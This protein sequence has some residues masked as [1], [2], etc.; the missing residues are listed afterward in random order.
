LTNGTTYYYVVAATNT[1]GASANSA[2]AVGHP[3]VPVA[4]ITASGGAGQVSL[5]WNSL[6]GASSYTVERS[7]TAGGPYTNLVSGLTATSYTDTSVQAGHDYYYIVMAQLSNGGQSGISAEV[8]ALTAP[9][10]PSLVLSQF[11][12][13]VITINPATAD[14][15][16]PQYSVEQSMDGVTFTPLGTVL[17]GATG[18]TNTDVTLNTTYY[19]RAKAQNATGTSGYSSVASITTPKF[20]INVNFANGANGQP[21]NNPAPVPPGYVQDVGDVYGDRG[22][23]LSYGWD[24]DITADGRWRQ[25]AVSPDLRYD[26][27]IHLE[28]LLPSAVWEI[29]IPNGTY[30][31]HIVAGDASNI[32]SVY[33]FDIE[34]AVTDTYTPV[35][36]AWWGEWTNEVQVAD[37]RLTI[38]SGPDASNNKIAFIDIYV[39]GT[40]TT[41]LVLGNPV[42][43]GNNFTVSWSGNARLQ[44][45]PDITGPWTDV[46]G[47][48]QGTYTA[49]VTAPRKFYRLA[50]P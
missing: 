12:T 25:A 9:S 17:A 4:G 27:F 33:E 30:Q 48:P 14:T 31:V 23:G 42:L 7:P 47:N 21:A 29:E 34:G 28:K 16:P 19:F 50:S 11:A 6:S 43:A 26:T 39:P 44:E 49:Q 3:N 20:G 22:N 10:I 35:T 1:F 8:S 2:E 46:T 15:V 41:P 36:G 38:T 13:T 45:A 5:A 40:A 37:G 24:Y 32:D 18:L